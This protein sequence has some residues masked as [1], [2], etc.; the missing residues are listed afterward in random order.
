MK[1]QE[2]KKL[3]LIALS[4]E[5]SFMSKDNLVKVNES[6][7][8]LWMCELQEW[9][10]EK[11]DIN[12][13]IEYYNSTKTYQYT[14]IHYHEKWDFYKGIIYYNTYEKALQKGLL[15]AL[16]LIKWKKN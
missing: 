5:K 10:R 14:I 16:K 13:G 1:S 7:Y 3:E 2:E 9:L 15:E 6:Y 12:I 4:R 8:Y 11:Y